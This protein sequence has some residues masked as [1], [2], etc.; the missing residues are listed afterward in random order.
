MSAFLSIRA[1]IIWIELRTIN[2]RRKIPQVLS[3]NDEEWGKRLGST[4][5]QLVLKAKTPIKLQIISNENERRTRKGWA[6]GSLYACI[7]AK[8][9]VANWFF[10]GAKVKFSSKPRSFKRSWWKYDLL[11]LKLTRRSEQSLVKKLL[12]FLVS[13]VWALMKWLVGSER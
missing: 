1:L 13:E 12:F 6:L 8:F 10:S 7:C 9:V 5:V 11:C 2:T 4:C 3:Q